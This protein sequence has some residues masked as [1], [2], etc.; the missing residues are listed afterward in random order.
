MD[1]SYSGIMKTVKC[2]K[3]NKDMEIHRG[4]ATMLTPGLPTSDLITL[5]CK[6]C[7]IMEIY[8]RVNPK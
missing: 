2:S 3:C 7:D 4:N 6:K 1:I 8:T 5:I